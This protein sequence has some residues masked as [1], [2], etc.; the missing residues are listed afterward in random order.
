MPLS[1]AMCWAGADAIMRLRGVT[2][3]IAGVLLVSCVWWTAGP[4]IEMY[5]GAC[6]APY[7]VFGTC[8][9]PVSFPGFGKITYRTSPRAKP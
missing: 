1:G 3:T 8:E 9:R 6:F 2:R 7:R 4:W 5:F